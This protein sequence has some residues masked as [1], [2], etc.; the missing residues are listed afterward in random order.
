LDNSGKYETAWAP[1]VSDTVRTT[2]PPVLTAFGPRSPPLYHSWL[3]CRP[4]SPQSR[5][6][7]CQPPLVAIKGAPLPVSSPSSPL[8]LH[9]HCVVVP[10]SLS[11]HEMLPRSPSELP[12]TA[13]APHRRWELPRPPYRRPRLLLRSTTIAARRSVCAAIEPLAPVSPPLSSA[14]KPVRHPAGLLSGH[15]TTAHWPPAGR[16]LPTTR[17]CQLGRRPP[18]FRLGPKG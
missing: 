11:C 14:A 2:V 8:P 16:I 5:A 3:C 15:S 4:R 1:L 12:D 17:R 18:L 10:P 13:R 9:Y 7:I 6:A